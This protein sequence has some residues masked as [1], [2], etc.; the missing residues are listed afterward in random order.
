MQ[1][2][3]ASPT[4]AVANLR[5]VLCGETSPQIKDR[6]GGAR[7]RRCTLELCLGVHQVRHLPLQLGNLQEKVTTVS[8]VTPM[9]RPD[10]RLV[11][12]WKLSLR[13]YTLVPL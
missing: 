8:G 4:A 7:P 2:R 5:A 3:C 10:T 12:M 11:G 13:Q 1:A 9:C 6:A